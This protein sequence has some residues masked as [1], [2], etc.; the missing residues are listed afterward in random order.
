M[1]NVIFTAPIYK[2]S[3]LIVGIAP[4]SNIGYKFESTESNNNLV[5]EYGD[6]KYQKYGTGSINQFF[7]GAAMN[8]SK[9]FSLGAEFTYYFG[10]INKYSNINFAD[11]SAQRSVKT[12]WD[13]SLSAVSGRLGLQY[14]GKVGNNKELTIGA[15]LRKKTKLKGEMLQYAYASSSSVTDTIRHNLVKDYKVIIPNEVAF[16]FS[17]RSIDKWLIGAD[18]IYQNWEKA[19]LSSIPG[20]SFIPT[21][22]HNVK[23]GVEYIPNKYDIRYYMK[24]VTYRAGAYF[25]QTYINVNGKQVNAAGITFGM[26]LPIYRWYNAINWSLDFGQR[27]MLQRDMVRER[28]V[29]LN[30]N[31]SLHD[32]WFIKKKYQ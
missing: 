4:Y 24:R 12:G 19:S 10:A 31:I 8:L 20:I 13:Y 23:L 9:N 7:I 3:A 16:G 25:E 17:L 27:G 30:L 18:Y 28:Y 5:A 1:Q 26:A 14:F 29:Q 15:T 6:I 11:A 21:A 2:K 22:S 32:L